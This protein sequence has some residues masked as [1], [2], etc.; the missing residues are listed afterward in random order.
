MQIFIFTYTVQVGNTFSLSHNIFHF[1]FS[2]ILYKNDFQLHKISFFKPNYLLSSYLCLIT[3][4]LTKK[5]QLNGKN[6][7]AIF[8]HSRNVYNNTVIHWGICL[9]SSCTTLDAQLFTKAVFSSVVEEIEVLSVIVDEN[10]C[11]YEKMIPITSSEII[12]G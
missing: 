4:N 8:Q 3:I 11:V 10:K 5:N 1:Y 12:Y 9:P 6:N 7:R 2:S